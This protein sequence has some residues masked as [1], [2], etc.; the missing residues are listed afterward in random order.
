MAENKKFRSALTGAEMEKLL[1]SIPD[2]M[3]ND[4][5]TQDTE[6]TD[7]SSVLSAAVANALFKK[8]VGR[9]EGTGVKEMLDKAPNVHALTDDILNKIESLKLVFIGSMGATERDALD[10]TEFKGGEVLLLLNSEN[11]S[12]HIQHWDRTADTWVTAN[13]LE[14]LY[15]AITSVSSGE[16]VIQTFNKEQYRTATFTVSARA[17]GFFHVSHFTLGWENLDT[18]ISEYGSVMNGDPLFTLETEVASNGV[19]VK[20]TTIKNNSRAQIEVQSVY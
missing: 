1:R 7:T 11:T 14:G 4:A 13:T 5:I 16:S 15:N 8:L 20:V 12:G 17:A 3:N 19:H 18:F 10:T 2:K 6:S 9:T